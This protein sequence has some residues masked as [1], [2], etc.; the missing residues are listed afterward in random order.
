MSDG[1]ATYDDP[2]VWDKPLREIVQDAY[3]AGYRSGFD[4]G[5]DVLKRPSAQLDDASS[6]ASSR[7]PSDALTRTFGT[8]GSVEQEDTQPIEV[9]E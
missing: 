6:S 2:D 5:R 3:N 1:E 7:P 8:L 9:D 4:D